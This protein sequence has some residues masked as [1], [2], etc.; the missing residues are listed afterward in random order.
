M[1]RNWHSPEGNLYMTAVFKASI[2]LKKLPLFTLYAALK[3]CHSLSGL[4]KIPLW[5]KWPNDIWV[6]KKKCAGF[7]A[8]SPVTPDYGRILLFGAGLNVN[9]TEFPKDLRRIATSFRKETHREWPLQEMETMLRIQILEAYDSFIKGNYE[10]ELVA[11][12]RS[13]ERLVGLNVKYEDNG[14]IRKGKVM[15]LSPDGSLNILS[16]GAMKR[17]RSGEVTL[18]RFLR[19]VGRG[20]KPSV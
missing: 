17:I 11:L 8:E 16:G 1:G 12:W 9:T 14:V 10:E 3:V 5:L 4:A 15:G 20:D 2:E 18:S 6:G 13:H 19:N 7:L